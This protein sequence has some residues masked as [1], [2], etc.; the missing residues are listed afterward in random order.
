MALG[1]GLERKRSK[2][3]D[4]QRQPLSSGCASGANS[5]D[6]GAGYVNISSS[7]V[8]VGRATSPVDAV[9]PA[10]SRV[11]AGTQSYAETYASSLGLARYR[12]QASSRAADTCTPALEGHSFLVM[13]YVTKNPLRSATFTTSRK[14]YV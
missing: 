10:L 8:R 5:G 3:N 11:K 12:L 4:L 1:K 6:S 13:R 14:C 7:R 9:V 2:I